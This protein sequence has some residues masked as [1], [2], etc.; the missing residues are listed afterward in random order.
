MFLGRSTQRRNMVGRLGLVVGLLGG[1]L[2][3]SDPVLAA[4]RSTVMVGANAITVD[5]KFTF[6]HYQ[7]G[8]TMRLTVDYFATCNIV[9]SGL[10]LQSPQPFSPPQ[11]VTG[12]IGNVTGGPDS[13]SAATSGS[14]SFDITFYS[15]KAF[16]SKLFG[17]ASLN[18]MLGVDSDCNPHTGDSDGVDR[19]A[20][21]GVQVLVVALPPPPPPKPPGYVTLGTDPNTHLP[22]YECDQANGPAP[23]V[24]YY[25]A[26]TSGN[27]GVPPSRGSGL[28]IYAP[29]GAQ[30]AAV[31]AAIQ[32]TGGVPV[33]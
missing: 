10:A 7:I 17:I 4:N 1:L 33:H 25:L 2:L 28:P 8:S 16:G 31:T 19:S 15:L 23:G 29:T 11:V 6:P 24:N 20:T 14:V 21:V 32:L 30:A 27:L 3:S 12:G 22:I 5:T 18:L 13:G 9:F 26:G